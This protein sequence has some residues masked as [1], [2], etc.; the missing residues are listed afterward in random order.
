M[1]GKTQLKKTRSNCSIACSLDVLGDKWT[2]LIIRDALFLNKKSFNEFR[3]SPE[4]IASN[5]LA[6][7]LEKL[8][9]NGIMKKSPN[10]AN[11]LKYDYVLTEKG[12][13][14][15]PIILALAE[16]GYENIEGTN[17]ASDYLNLS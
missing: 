10:E 17:A 8:V 9:E 5:I 13:Q 15:K 12:Q 2:L 3:Y 14:L 6:N 7:R 16:W 11:K 1:E 4:K